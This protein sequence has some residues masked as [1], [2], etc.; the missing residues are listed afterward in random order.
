MGVAGVRTA[1]A[2]AVLGRRGLRDYGRGGVDCGHGEG[3]GACDGRTKNC[4]DAYTKDIR[5]SRY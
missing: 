2:A 4:V 3:G 1:G 5:S